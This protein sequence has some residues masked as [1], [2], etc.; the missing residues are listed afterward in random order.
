MIPTRKTRSHP[1]GGSILA[2]RS[3]TLDGMKLPRM[4][5]GTTMGRCDVTSRAS[6]AI[7]TIVPTVDSLQCL[8]GCAHC[9]SLP[10]IQ[11]P[12]CYTNVNTSFGPCQCAAGQLP[13]PFNAIGNDDL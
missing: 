8:A 12:A 9:A 10:A 4:A 11:Q 13:Q 5:K 3:T 6:R 7:S 1:H 2:P